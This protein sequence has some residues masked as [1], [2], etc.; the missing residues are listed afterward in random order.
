M[1][2]FGLQPF[3]LEGPDDSFHLTPRVHHGV[4]ACGNSVAARRVRWASVSASSPVSYGGAA[5]TSACPAAAFRKGLSETGFDEGENVGV[6]YYRLEGEYQRLPALIGGIGERRVS[7]ITTP[8]FS[9]GAVAAK[10]ATGAIPIE[11]K[12]VANLDTF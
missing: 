4:L 9:P 6:E 5:D 3:R 1:L 2:S 10:T 12:G 7:V 11:L 8:G